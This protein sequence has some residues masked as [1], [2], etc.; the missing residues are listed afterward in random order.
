DRDS[1]DANQR[2]QGYWLMA[3]VE[4]N[5]LGIGNTTIFGEYGAVD[6]NNEAAA[7]YERRNQNGVLQ[8]TFGTPTDDRLDGTYW[9]LGLVQTIDS[10]ATDL[11]INFR[12][13]ELDGTAYGVECPV[14]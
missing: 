12:R 4:K 14:W 2:Q 3:G 11:Y 1:D 7:T 6:W 8:A 5:W 13:Y 10:A 9:G